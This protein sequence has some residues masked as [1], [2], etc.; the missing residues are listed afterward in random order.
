M[1]ALADAF[2]G[3]FFHRPLLNTP[4]W[5]IKYEFWGVIY[6]YIVFSFV[7]KSIWRKWIARF[8]GGLL[9]YGLTGDVYFCVVYLG[10]VLGALL[11]DDFNRIIYRICS[12]KLYIYCGRA[13]LIMAGILSCIFSSMYVKILFVV[14]LISLLPV[15]E[16]M[17][18]IFTWKPLLCLSKYTYAIYAV[19]WPLICS[20]TCC[21][22]VRFSGR[23]ARLCIYIG[24]FFIIIIAG[25][26]IEQI[27]GKISKHLNL[28]LVRNA[29]KSENIKY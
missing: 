24:S 17:Q 14:I 26:L 9:L 20:L 13:A 19:H 2:C 4:L 15:D 12:E 3:S 21:L 25:C 22:Y 29:E 5:T 8:A 16:G 18:N 7:F 1:Q 27:N 6:V 10:A 11:F 23:V 28:L